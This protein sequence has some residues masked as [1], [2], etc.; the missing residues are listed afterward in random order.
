M[1][2]CARTDT[3]NHSKDQVRVWHGES[4]PMSFCGFHA[5]DRDSINIVRRLTN[6]EETK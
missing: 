4:V 5:Q 6:Q 1:V 3:T 2:Q